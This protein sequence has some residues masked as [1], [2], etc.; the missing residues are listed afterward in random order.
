MLDF[1]NHSQAMIFNVS[2]SNPQA[3]ASKH[4]V[5]ESRKIGNYTT[6]P[7]CNVTYLSPLA[8]P[9]HSTRQDRIVKMIR[10][11]LRRYRIRAEIRKT[12]Q[13][14]QLL[15]AQALQLRNM[16]QQQAELHEQCSYSSEEE[17]DIYMCSECMM[18]FEFR[19]DFYWHMETVHAALSDDDDDDM[20]MFE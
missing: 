13:R 15:Q 14:R 17:S 4:D 6:C 7:V 10:E 20:F 8:H 12:L 5:L 18:D 1:V 9:P 19:D 11:M 2:L 3:M 16:L